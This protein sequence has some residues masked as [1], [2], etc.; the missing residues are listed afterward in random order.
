MGRPR[1]LIIDSDAG[2]SAACAY[3]LERLG[4]ETNVVF[5]PAHALTKADEFH[6]HVA[7][8]DIGMVDSSGLTIGR[9]LRDHYARHELALV[10]VSLYGDPRT[11]D[12]STAAGFDAHLVKPVNERDL[13]TIVE[14]V[15]DKRLR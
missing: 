3:T 13:R 8:I 7:F 5:D 14:L 12:C 4:F 2:F 6:P 1:V 10:A 15:L 9:L 11:R